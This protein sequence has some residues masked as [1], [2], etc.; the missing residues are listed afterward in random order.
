MD[1]LEFANRPRCRDAKG[2]YEVWYVTVNQPAEGRGFWI[3]Y[4]TLNPVDGA[5]AEPHAALWAASFDRAAPERNVALKAVHP[6]SAVAYQEPFGIAIGDAFLDVRGCRGS[7]TAPGGT[8]RWDLTWTSHA[9]PFFIPEPAWLKV[10]SAANF[11]AQ[12]CLEV[13][14]TIEIGG[15]TFE[16]DRA[17]GGQ[18]HTWG[19]RHALE[20]NWGFAAGLGG[21]RGEFLDGVSTRVRGPGGVTLGGTALGLLAGERSVRVSSLPATLRNGAEI[22]PVG[23]DAKVSDGG[24]T[25]EVS[26]R[27]RREDLVGVTY[28]DPA[29]GIRVCYHTEVADLDLTLLEEGREVFAQRFESAAAFEYASEKALPGLPP[30]L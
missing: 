9:E 14:G 22:S 24:L 23:W 15:V 10:V 17:Y 13:T 18:Q 29:G 28:A 5:G 1:R 21:R 25:A 16:L 2:T 11:G 12:P 19:R 6:L 20:W 3:R 8:A 30:V 27:P 4:T 26:I 7:L